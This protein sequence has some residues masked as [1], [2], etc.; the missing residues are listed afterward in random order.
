MSD[1]KHPDVVSATDSDT[2]THLGVCTACYA[3]THI[4]LNPLYDR[5]EQDLEEV[6]RWGV[7]YAKSSAKLSDGAVLSGQVEDVLTNIRRAMLDTRA[8]K[9]LIVEAVAKRLEEWN[10]KDTA[11]MVRTLKLEVAV[12]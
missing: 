7:H 9:N 2:G 3:V 5:I 8:N 4:C 12:E 11:E 10:K 6:R 1:C